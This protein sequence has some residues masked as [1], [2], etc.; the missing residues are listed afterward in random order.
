MSHSDDEIHTLKLKQAV[1]G[2]DAKEGQR[3]IVQVEATSFT[4]DPIQYPVL[5]LTNGRL[6]MVR[7]WTI[8]VVVGNF[9]INNLQINN[10]QINNLQINNLQINNL[11]INYL[12]INYLQINNL[13]INNLQINNLQMNN[14]LI[15]NLQI[16]AILII[17]YNYIITSGV[18]MIS[19][20]GKF[21]LAT[22]CLQ[23]RGAKPC[24]P[25][26]F[27]GEFF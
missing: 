3:N 17:L 8:S 16:D 9:Q 4:D 15:N 11:Q 20:K 14:L 10:L 6:D 5:S 12:Q 19:W 27:Y 23:K 2:A 26:F 24:F 21:L 25:I 1:L 7:F 22:I 13:Q 18:F